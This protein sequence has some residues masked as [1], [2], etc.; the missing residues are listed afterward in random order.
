MRKYTFFRK[1]LTNK[2]RSFYPSLLL[3]ALITPIFLVLDQMA[4][5]QLSVLQGDVYFN[6]PHTF[7]TSESSKCEVLTVLMTLLI[8]KLR[9][10]ESG[11]ER[12]DLK[13]YEGSPSTL[14]IW[15]RQ[16][17]SCARIFRKN[18]WEWPTC[19][20]KEGVFSEGRTWKKSRL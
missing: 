17:E 18:N 5:F 9:E 8:V 12:S 1:N 3:V 2:V 16:T 4:L 13:G 20:P 6:L 14:F 7:R 15:Q 10:V 19:T 11:R